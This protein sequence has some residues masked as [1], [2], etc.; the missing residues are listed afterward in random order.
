MERCRVA[1][2][3]D[4][5]E[6]AIPRLARVGAQFFRPVSE[7]QV[8]RAFDVCGGERLAVVP[9]YPVAEMK[10]QLRHI[11]VPRPF[12]GQIGNDRIQP[13]LRNILLEYDEIV[14]HGHHRILG[15]VERLLMNRHAGGAVVLINSQHA[16]LLLCQSRRCRRPA[17]PARNKQQLPIED[18]SSS[19]PSSLICTLPTAPQPS[20]SS[21]GT[22]LAQM[23]AAYR[24]NLGPDRVCFRIRQEH[25]GT[26]SIS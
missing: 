3:A 12:R 16:P 18:L 5:L 8:P 10:R 11:G 4:R 9:A 23:C 22:T 15:R 26:A 24:F 13:V 20:R 25:N 19:C 21:G 2:G 1:V 7:Y 17:Q 6:I 14:E